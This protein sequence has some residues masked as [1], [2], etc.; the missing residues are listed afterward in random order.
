MTIVLLH[1]DCQNKDWPTTFGAI[2]AQS[3]ASLAGVSCI[4]ATAYLNGLIPDAHPFHKETIPAI[5]SNSSGVFAVDCYDC[6]DT[7][8][9]RLRRLY[10]LVIGMCQ[11][12]Q[13]CFNDLRNGFFY[14]QI[15]GAGSR[16]VSKF[17]RLQDAEPTAVM[18]G[19]LDRLVDDAWEYN[20]RDYSDINR[21][22]R[23]PKEY[24]LSGLICEKAYVLF[25][26][27]V[28]AF[29]AKKGWR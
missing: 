4:H 3:H 12:G 19:V 25:D 11:S 8:V 10:N 16:D 28:S 15:R 21:K 29:V 27:E 6:N 13:C 7:G 20:L 18:A 22:K 5:H 23:A 2:V 9:R 24:R 17:S 26:D 14:L 1:T